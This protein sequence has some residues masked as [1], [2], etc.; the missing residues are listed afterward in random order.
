MKC[1]EESGTAMDV[2]R[3][4]RSC[5]RCWTSL[6]LNNLPTGFVS[7]SAFGDGGCSHVD[8]PIYLGKSPL[9]TISS[10]CC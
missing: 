10:Y 1:G 2:N 6:G 9:V 3:Q 8:L 7:S 5:Q 4:M